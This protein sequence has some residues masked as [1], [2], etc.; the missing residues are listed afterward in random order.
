MRGAP[1]TKLLQMRPKLPVDVSRF[2]IQQAAVLLHWL[3]GKGILYRDLKLSNIHIDSEFRVR[4]ID[5]GLSKRIGKSR[6]NSICGT[7]HASPPELTSAAGYGY[8]LDSFSLGVVA[9]ELLAFKPPFAYDC[10]FEDS[11][12]RDWQACRDVVAAIADDNARSFV[13]SLLVDED[14]RPDMSAVLAHP[15]VHVG[16]IANFDDAWKIES[17]KLVGK[18]PDIVE[19][20]ELVED[21]EQETPGQMIQF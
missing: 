12:K 21:V 13:Q 16:D 10:S 11:A 17:N 14:H 3:H 1:L 2:I 8:P 9:C 18:H 5:F 6:T 15:F 4:L 7:P 19:D 20:L